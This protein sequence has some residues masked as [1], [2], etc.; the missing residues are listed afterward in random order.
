VKITP[1]TVPSAART[2]TLAGPSTDLAATS[3]VTIGGSAIGPDGSWDG[4][5]TALPG[6]AGDGTVTMQLPAASA[7]VV[8]LTVK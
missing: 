2:I 5:W 1:G 7:A 8:D 3:G 6:I 4:K